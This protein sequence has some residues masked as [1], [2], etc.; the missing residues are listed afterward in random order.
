M[1]VV[2]VGMRCGG[3]LSWGGCRLCWNIFVHSSLRLCTVG[4]GCVCMWGVKD[5]WLLF[6]D[7]SSEV[8]YMEL[9]KLV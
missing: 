9:M 2:L 5:V 3:M 1:D 7:V 4:Q 8:L 6:V